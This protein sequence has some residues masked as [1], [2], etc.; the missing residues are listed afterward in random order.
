MR[1]CQDARSFR[2]LPDN[3]P[4]AYVIPSDEIRTAELGLLSTIMRLR[5]SFAWF[6]QFTE[7][8]SKKLIKLI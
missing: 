8:T 1:C 5:A 7:T 2:A 6:P 3:D 4:G